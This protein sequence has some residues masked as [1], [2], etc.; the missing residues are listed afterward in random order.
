MLDGGYPAWAAR[1][2]PK[3]IDSVPS[4]DIEAPG[5]AAQSPPGQSSYK[6]VLQARSRPAPTGSMRPICKPQSDSATVA[7]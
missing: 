1:G 4:E 3:E 6:A 7:C 5:K 2:L